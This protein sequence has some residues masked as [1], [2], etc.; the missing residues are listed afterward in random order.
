[1]RTT[2]DRCWLRRLTPKQERRLSIDLWTRL[3]H[4][5]CTSILVQY[6][7]DIRHISWPIKSRLASLQFFYFF[8]VIIL[9]IV[10]FQ[11]VQ[12]I[13]E[14]V[15]YVASLMSNHSKQV[16]IF[17]YILHHYYTLFV[18]YTKLQIQYLILI[19]RIGICIPRCPYFARFSYYY[20]RLA[21]ERIWYFV[22][23]SLIFYIN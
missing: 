5:V 6:D 21:F 11:C 16:I 14:Y 20:Y 3:H 8:I 22:Q 7:V 23:N 10:L 19:F 4:L 1:M 12:R 9:H 17:K 2:W 18:K 15:L 13:Y